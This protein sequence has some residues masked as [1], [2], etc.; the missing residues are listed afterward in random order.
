MDL[1]AWQKPLVAKNLE[2]N[3]Y[4]VRRTSSDGRDKTIAHIRLTTGKGVYNSFANV[5]K[6]CCG[7]Q[8][9]DRT[10]GKLS[11]STSVAEVEVLLFYE[12]VNCFNRKN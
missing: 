2:S 5:D 4:V 11:P 8:V 12:S 9:A 3:G 10:C 6:S 1:L 7:E